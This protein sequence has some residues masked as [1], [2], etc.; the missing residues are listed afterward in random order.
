MKSLHARSGQVHGH[1]TWTTGRAYK[2]MHGHHVCTWHDPISSGSGLLSGRGWELVCWLNGATVA[3]L[4]VDEDC[5]SR[6]EL[7]LHL[8]HFA[9]ERNFLCSVICPFACD[10][11][12]NDASQRVRTQPSSSRVTKA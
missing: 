10:E 11:C 1:K 12:F 2:E 7:L 9:V 5:S 3:C 4:I 8:E 6:V